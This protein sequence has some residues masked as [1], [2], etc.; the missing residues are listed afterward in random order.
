[1]PL[2]LTTSPPLRENGTQE[3]EKKERNYV[4]SSKNSFEKKTATFLIHRVYTKRYVLD[5]FSFFSFFFPSPIIS[6][7]GTKIALTEARI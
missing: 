1:M 3:R 6:H 4:Q 2:L 7:R 5:F